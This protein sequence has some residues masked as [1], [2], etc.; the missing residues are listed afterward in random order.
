MTTRIDL[1]ER[2]QILDTPCY[3][4]LLDGDIGPMDTLIGTVTYV[5]TMI[6]VIGILLI[7]SRFGATLVHHC[8]RH[9]LY[10]PRI[11]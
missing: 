8:T 2:E 11:L 3:L 5:A 6:V 10:H 7:C 1:M 4:Q 9:V